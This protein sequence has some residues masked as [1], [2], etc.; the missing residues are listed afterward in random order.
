M[1]LGY[2]IDYS[3]NPHEVATRVGEMEQAGLDVVWAA[4]AYGFD[5]VSILGFVAARTE[6][7][8]VGSAILNVYSRT[9]GALAQTAAGLDAVSEGRFELG[10]GASGPQVIEGWHGM[11]YDRPLTRTE[12]VIDLVRRMVARDVVEHD[13]E[14]FTLPLPDDEGLGLGKPLKMLTHPVRDRLPI[15]VAALGPMNV[16]MTA[17]VADGW[18]PIFYWPERARDVWGESLDAGTAARDRSL[19]QLDTIVNVAFGVAEGEQRRQLLD[20]LRPHYALYVGGMGSR[21]KNFYNDLAV[22]YGFTEEAATVQ[23]LYLTGRKDEAAAA[24]PERLVEQ[25]N[26]IGSE[27][28]VR[29]RLDAYREAG[30]TTLNITPMGDPVTLTGTLRQWL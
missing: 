23:D 15:H 16:E 2:T 30:V 1:R 28:F 9:P 12:E 8:A 21:E 26:L 19:G 17:R 27:G 22:R 4:E 29:E 5:S 13:G 24:I 6:R 14:V 25:T 3:G 11:P 10:L 20:R 18:M 7:V